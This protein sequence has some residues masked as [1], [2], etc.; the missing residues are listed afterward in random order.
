[1]RPSLLLIAASLVLSPAFANVSEL[2]GECGSL[3]RS[4]ASGIVPIDVEA[5][6]PTAEQC[7]SEYEEYPALKL[8]AA[9]GLIIREEHQAAKHWISGTEIAQ[10]HE[11]AVLDYLNWS[12]A[13][14]RGQPAG[15]LLEEFR[16]KLRS[17][18]S[19]ILVSNAIGHALAKTG[20]FEEAKSVLEAANK[21]SGDQPFNLRLLTIVYFRLGEI[22]RSIDAGYRA[23]AIEPALETDA[24]FMVSL[25]WSFAAG[26]DR[27]ASE[28]ILNRLIAMSPG[29]RDRPVVREYQKWL[30]EN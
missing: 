12:I 21:A 29:S 5:I 11:G 27:R 14:T 24:P 10:S 22:G 4:L 13:H 2:E 6:E 17:I 1:M 30:A 18:E 7:R 15:K 16:R 3:V 19:S 26:G 8:G 28:R 23:L 20:H 9:I 25:S